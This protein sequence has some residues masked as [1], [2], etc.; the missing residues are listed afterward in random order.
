MGEDELWEANAEFAE[1]IFSSP[2][3][4]SGLARF[5]SRKS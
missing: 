3:M 4:K 5:E 1:R 2:A